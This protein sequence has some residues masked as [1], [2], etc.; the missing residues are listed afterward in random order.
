MSARMRTFFCLAA[1]GWLASAVAL[2][3]IGGR[4]VPAAPRTADQD[5]TRTIWSG[6]Y[7]A[8]Q[9]KRGESIADKTCTPCHGPDLAGGQDGPSLVGPDV[10][11]AWSSMTLGELFDRIRTAMPADA[12][13]SLSAQDAADVLAYLISVDKC[14]A[15]DKELPADQDALNQIRIVRQPGAER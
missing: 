5:S 11:Q 10:L 6:V 3:A 9:A 13:R 14:P 15:G 7:A 12:P 4:P 1:S 8:A 2:G